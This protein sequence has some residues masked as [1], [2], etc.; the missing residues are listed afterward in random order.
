MA[1]EG[2]PCSNDKYPVDF[3]FNFYAI[4]YFYALDDLLIFL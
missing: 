2:I 3:G 1:L 4:D